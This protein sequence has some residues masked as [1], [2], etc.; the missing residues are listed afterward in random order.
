MKKIITYLPEIMCY[1]A[2]F[3]AFC[4]LLTGC[5]SR[6]FIES[7]RQTIDTV[8]PEYIQ[9]VESDQ[10]LTDDDKAI[11]RAN[12]EHATKTVEKFENTKW[13]W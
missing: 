12:L 1:V 9:Y 5:V 2:L 7:Y 11:R 3:I 8:G 13:S 6:Q 10:N 4:N